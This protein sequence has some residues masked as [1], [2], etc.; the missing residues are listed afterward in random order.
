MVG[1]VLGTL[2]DRTIRPQADSPYLGPVL[3]KY[4]ERYGG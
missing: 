1:E 3:Q 4:Q 2:I